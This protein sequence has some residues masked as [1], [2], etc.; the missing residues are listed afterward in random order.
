MIRTRADARPL[1]PTIQRI[2][3]SY[4]P[5]QPPPDEATVDQRFS[6]SLSP[7]RFNA[8]VIGGFALVAPLLAVM[9]VYGVMSYLVALRAKEVG[10]RMA[11]GARP[12][13]VVA[14]IVREGAV[15]GVIGAVLGV[16]GA[17]VL[18]RYLASLLVNVSP[19]DR[20]V[21]VGLTAVLLVA[22]LAACY[23]PGQ[24]AA[25]ADPLVV[26]RHE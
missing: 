9:G 21:F 14:M 16:T 6:D 23:V 17:A 13:N 15:L 4:T 24:R 12:A 20:T 10:I 1:L 8:A 19:Y 25:E 26:L 22:V 2:L 7:R 5:Q 18:T 3:A 11:L